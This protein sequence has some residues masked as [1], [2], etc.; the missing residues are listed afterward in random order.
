[1]RGKWGS[2]ACR[3]QRGH[4]WGIPR[5]GALEGPSR[6]GRGLRHGLSETLEG[7]GLQHGGT[8][9]WNPASHG[10]RTGKPTGLPWALTALRRETEVPLDLNEAL[11]QTLIS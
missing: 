11:L 3:G 2:A 7:T 4:R 6:E 5:L 8:G 9:V 1:M 10:H